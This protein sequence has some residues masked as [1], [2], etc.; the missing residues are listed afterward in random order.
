MGPHRL[1]LSLQ[2]ARIRS[3]QTLLGLGL[4]SGQKGPV[5]AEQGCIVTPSHLF[6]PHPSDRASKAF[7]AN[8]T[9]LRGLPWSSLSWG[10][11]F[12]VLLS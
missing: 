1:Q 7:P 2:T 10:M 12:G 4:A 6:T 5:G 9:K 11:K 3:Q 8:F